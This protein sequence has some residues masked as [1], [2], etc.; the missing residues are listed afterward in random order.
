VPVIEIAGAIA[1]VIFSSGVPG[2]RRN[3]VLV[4]RVC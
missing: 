4:L 3:H 2:G 1:T